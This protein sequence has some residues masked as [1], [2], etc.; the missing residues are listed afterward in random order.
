MPYFICIRHGGSRRFEPTLTQTA[1]SFTSSQGALRHIVYCACC[2][3]SGVYIGKGSINWQRNYVLGDLAWRVKYVCSL[4]NC[5]CF[6]AHI[7]KSQQI[8]SAIYQTSS[9]L[10]LKFSSHTQGLSTEYPLWKRFYILFNLILGGTNLTA[11]LELK[12]GDC[13]IGVSQSFAVF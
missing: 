5:S 13:F 1:I 11:L 7:N 3:T 6:T 2:V 4:G 12:V 8:G 10:F 9:L